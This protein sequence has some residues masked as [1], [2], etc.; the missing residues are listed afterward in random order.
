MDATIITALA[1]VLTISTFINTYWIYKNRIIF[2]KCLNYM[3]LYKWETPDK[4]KPKTFYLILHDLRADPIVA[5][6]IEDNDQCRNYWFD[7][8]ALTEVPEPKY[9]I[10][11]DAIK[12]SVKVG[13]PA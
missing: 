3:H 9:I 2:K 1:A 11:I 10:S 5:M 6:Y 12:A 8:K 13:L 7:Y 4:A